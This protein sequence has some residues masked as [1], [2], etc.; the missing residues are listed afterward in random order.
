MSKHHPDLVL[1]RKQTGIGIGKMCQACEGRCPIC[2]S[3]VKPYALVRVCDECDYGT[4]HGKCIIC[5]AKGIAD[6]Y[7]CKEC[8]LMEKDRENCP[9]VVNVAEARKDKFYNSKSDKKFKSFFDPFFHCRIY[10]ILQLLYPS[11]NLLK[12]KMR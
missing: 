8:V 10:Q 3:Y 1:C 6:A 12:F 4:N 11:F 7:Y 5:G 9:R 2:D